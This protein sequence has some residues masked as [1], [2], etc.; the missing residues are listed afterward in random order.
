MTPKV[1]VEQYGTIHYCAYCNNC[2]WSA[3]IFADG[4]V[5]PTQVRSAA[6]KHVLATKHTVSIESGKSTRYSY[7]ENRP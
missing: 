7:K 6:R 3:C 2:E 1:V 4:L 5:T